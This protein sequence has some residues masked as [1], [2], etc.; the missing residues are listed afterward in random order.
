M[1]WWMKLN[2]F[3]I[4]LWKQ[5]YS[6]QR[7]TKLKYRR[8]FILFLKLQFCSVVLSPQVCAC[9]TS[10]S[11]SILNLHC[12]IYYELHLSCM[13]HDEF[14]CHTIRK[15]SGKHLFQFWSISNHIYYTHTCK[16]KPHFCEHTIMNLIFRKYWSFILDR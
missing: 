4:I 9:K 16:L 14:W 10:F 1:I 2:F 11:S 5:I 8:K 15:P 12:F 6:Q 13:M 3:L 7:C